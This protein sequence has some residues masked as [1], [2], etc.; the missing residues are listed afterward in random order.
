MFRCRVW[1]IALFCLCLWSIPTYSQLIGYRDD[2]DSSHQH[3]GG[4]TEFG[5]E[6]VLAGTARILTKFSFDYYANFLPGTNKG[7]II[8]FYGNPGPAWKGN[9]DYQ[10][11]STDPIWVSPLI[12]L[13]QG[14]Y[15]AELE[16]PSIRVPDH[17]TWTIEYKNIT[18]GAFFTTNGVVNDIAGLL[19]YGFPSMG[20]SY[21]DFWEFLPDGWTPVRLVGITKNNFG[22]SAT[23]V[24]EVVEPLLTATK[25]TNG[26]LLS[27]K[28]ALTD[29]F[30]QSLTAPSTNWVA[31]SI[32]PAK[33][34]DYFERL[35][36][37]STNTTYRLKQ[38]DRADGLLDVRQ[39]TNSSIRIRWPAAAR[40]FVLQWKPMVGSLGWT[41]VTTP[42]APTGDFYEVIRK[43]TG[44]AEMYRLRDTVVATS[45]QITA[46]PEGVRVRWPQAAWGYT[47]QGKGL[48]DWTNLAKPTNAIDGF[49]QV[50]VPS[51]NEFQMF[52][53]RMPLGPAAPAEF[54]AVIEPAPVAPSAPTN[55]SA[56]ALTANDV[57]LTWTDVATNESGFKIY[58]K[59]GT[60]AYAQ[61][62][63]VGAN[64]TAFTNTVV[65]PAVYSFMVTA[66][67]AVG[68]SAGSNEAG[69]TIATAITIPSAPLFTSATATGPSQVKLMWTDLST[70]EVGFLIFRRLVSS[71]S[72]TLIQ[73][74]AA[75]ATS[76][77]DSGVTANSSY[78][79][80][81]R[82]FN[83]AGE[84]ANSAIGVTTPAIAVLGDSSE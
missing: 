26:V 83:S 55:L 65:S 9:S 80:K 32:T 66:F 14:Y 47:L 11:P 64:V 16:V 40:G 39:A 1:A 43:A 67:N 75:N 10:L 45:L 20:I 38:L 35:V 34:G 4:I 57:K 31:D 77:L 51:T 30:L 78:I 79:Y 59:S 19:I 21:D 23:L 52:R 5:D 22:A 36:S 7:A 82:S 72:Y 71:S 68:E 42:A 69:I 62:G 74:T 50:V 2:S 76:F 61:I 63:S 84:S 25:T 48:N 17:L 60:G 33:N 41:D 58:R 73:T 3:F 27:W 49:Y 37:D 13:N 70:N 54:P 8:R 15:T 29:Y 18:Q 46:V 53:L 24:P 12:P 81:I 44:L 28:T 6:I 56:S